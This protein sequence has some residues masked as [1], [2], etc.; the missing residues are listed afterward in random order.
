VAGN[1]RFFMRKFALYCKYWECC[2]SFW[3]RESLSF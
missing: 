3:E 1:K 2:A